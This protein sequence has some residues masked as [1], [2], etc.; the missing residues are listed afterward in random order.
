MTLLKCYYCDIDFLI[1]SYN[2]KHNLCYFDW[3][4]L[5]T[6]NI[7]LYFIL[8]KILHNLDISGC[9]ARVVCDFFLLLSGG[10]FFVCHSSSK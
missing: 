4:S 3:V 5:Q 9:L 7:F 2:W 6:R 10:K 8:E 1:K